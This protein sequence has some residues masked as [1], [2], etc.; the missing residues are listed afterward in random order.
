MCTWLESKVASHEYMA[1]AHQLMQR[2]LD[3]HPI[4]VTRT[5]WAD[6]IPPALRADGHLA[7]CMSRHYEQWREMAPDRCDLW[8]MLRNG[9]NDPKI[10]PGYPYAATSAAQP[11]RSDSQRAIEEQYP[12]MLE[13]GVIT[14]VIDPPS[15]PLSDNQYHILR[16]APQDKYDENGILSDEVRVVTATK[17]ESSNEDTPK[18][19][20]TAPDDFCRWVQ[21]RNVALKGDLSK[22]FWQVRATHGQSSRMMFYWEA[23][24]FKWTVMVMGMAGSGYWATNI[25]NVIRSYLRVKFWMD[26]FTYVDEWIQQHPVTLMT[27]LNQVF[28]VITLVWLGARPNMT[29]T[30]LSFERGSTPTESLFIGIMANSM[31]NR[32]SP[33]PARVT[34]IRTQ[35]TA[36]ERDWR[37]GRPVPWAQLRQLKSRIISCQRVHFLAG[38]LTV[39]MATVHRQFLRKWGSSKSSHRATIPH[40]TLQYVMSEVQYWAVMPESESWRPAR[41]PLTSATVVV[42]AST[43]RMAMNGRSSNLTGFFFTAPMSPIERQTSHNAMEA[44]SAVRGVPV[45]LRDGHLPG[46][47][48]QSPKL[49]SV[50][51]DNVTTVQAFNRLTT[52]SLFIAAMMVT[53]MRWQA[54]NHFW[55]SGYYHPKKLMDTQ[56]VKRGLAAGMTTDEASRVFGG[57]W[58]RAIPM[59]LFNQVCTHFGIPKSRVIDM[60][61]CCQS[62]RVQRFVSRTPDI[63]NLWTDALSPIFPWD[64]TTNP[65]I[66]PTDILYC[67]PPPKILPKVIQRMEHTSNFVLLVARF[68][69]TLPAQLVQSQQGSPPLVFGIEVSDLIPPEGPE[70]PA[71]VGER[72]T[73]LASLFSPPSSSR[74]EP[75]LRPSAK[76]SVPDGDQHRTTPSQESVLSPGSRLGRIGSTAKAMTYSTS[77]GRR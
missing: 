11:P 49:L 41:Y 48:P 58:T 51:A 46:G 64:H 35:A 2:A 39:R 6:L 57:M 37:A 43:Y 9:W 59:H 53:F 29:K 77:Q 36:I 3:G 16:N 20:G 68:D 10:D 23:Q 69:T 67:F 60:F 27:Y 44:L 4:D 19:R 55:V 72:M 56:K 12:K 50:L 74:V 5:D 61:A 13:M 32:V 7:G 73:L 54:E 14:R 28:T 66:S 65:H 21:P 8:R 30:Q 15:T 76:L 42:D 47:T 18:Y 45:L 38:F 62:T 24:L 33:A 26:M 31:I 25:T 71:M 40:D 22:M 52:T 34:S 75:N 1:P 70:A 17:Q 63:Q